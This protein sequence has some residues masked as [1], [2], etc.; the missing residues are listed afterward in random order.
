VHGSVLQNKKYI[1]FADENT[2]E[3]LVLD[4][5]EE[6]IEK[7]E[8]GAATFKA[9]D[10]DGQEKEFF[11]GWPNLTLDDIKG[12]RSTKAGTYNNTGKIPYTAIVNPHTE[13]E[14]E[15]I[16]G[17]Y[18]AGALMDIVKARRQELVKEYGKGVS[19]KTLQ[20]V[21]EAAADIRAKTAEG[22]LMKA[23][24]DSAA[25][26]KK[27]AKEGDAILDMVAKVR[28]DV[29]EAAGNQLDELEAMIGR[30]EKS[31]AA[32]EL[33]RLAR[34]LKGTELEERASTLLESA[35]A[36]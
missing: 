15:N 17:G 10:E 20:K 35:K 27:M 26:A 9:K 18:G 1:K 23:L 32:R 3:V 25:L 12:M 33:S 4:R 5:L 24:T 22:D 11:L 28:A 19:R 13:E 34:Y 8:K 2:V 7:E 16:K 30:G 6:A 36:K 21:K 14:M 29:L 31:D